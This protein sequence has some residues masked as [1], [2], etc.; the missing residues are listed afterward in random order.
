MMAKGVIKPTG[1]GSVPLRLK[2]TNGE[3][4]SLTLVNVNYVPGLPT[5]LFSGTVIWKSNA[6]ICEKTDAVYT[7]Q[8]NYEI[9]ALK[10]IGE[11][12]F[13]DQDLNQDLN[14]SLPWAT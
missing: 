12:L 9:A 13:L 8:G 5:N 6:Y 7:K 14:L 3:S 2:T 11:S 4:V 1:S 10:A